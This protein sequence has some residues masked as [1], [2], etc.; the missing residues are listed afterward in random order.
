VGRI[1]IVTPAVWHSTE[2][3]GW[4]FSAYREGTEAESRAYDAF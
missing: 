4:L 3:R 1:R 2:T